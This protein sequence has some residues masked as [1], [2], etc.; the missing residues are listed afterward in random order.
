MTPTSYYDKYGYFFSSSQS[1]QFDGCKKKWEYDKFSNVQPHKM[2]FFPFE[3]GTYV[4]DMLEHTLEAKKDNVR[5]S[6]MFDYI[7]R[8]PRSAKVNTHMGRNEVMFHIENVMIPRF[9]ALENAK[10]TCEIELGVKAPEDWFR[11]GYL[12]AFLPHYP[13]VNFIGF[14]GKIDFY[15]KDMKDGKI[16]I[17]DWKTGKPRGYKMKSYEEQVAQYSYLFYAHGYE[18]DE[19]SLYF[20]DAREEIQISSDVEK[21]EDLIRT[22]LKR[23]INWLQ[24]NT[25]FPKTVSQDCNICQFNLKCQKNDSVVLQMW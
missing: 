12:D 4:H 18:F 16:K 15:G 14:R 6:R 11:E 9:Q 1:D 3:Y 21:G 22:K 8:N 23:H 17:I 5:K 20:V 24:D 25:V 19:V 13:N 10:Q 7:S 2:N